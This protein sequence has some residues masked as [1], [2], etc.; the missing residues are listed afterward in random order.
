MRS[1]GA[2]SAALRP[3][4]EQRVSVLL[5]LPLAGAYD[6]AVPD[7]MKI[8]PGDFA[9]VPLGS[10][11]VVGVVWDKPLG[12][13]GGESVP[14]E[15]LREIEERLPAPPMPEAL[16][17]FIEWV[18]A[19]TVAPWGAVLRMALSAPAALLPPK[20]VLAARAADAPLEAFGLKQ[21][22]AR[23]RVVRLLADG[24]PRVLSE[25]AREAGVGAAVLRQMLQSGALEQVEM[26]PPPPFD[27]PDPARPGPALSDAQREAAG[28]LRERV[29][30]GYSVTLLDGV[31][32]SGKTEVYFE[33]I[34]AALDAGKQVLVLLPEIALSAQW[35][36]RFERRF[37]AK[38]AT[39]H[40]DLTGA[41]RRTT[42]RA[43]AEGTA[44][45]VVGARS[46][47]FLPLPELGLII[48]DE[49]HEG[50]YKQEDGV[51]YHA[52]DMAVVRAHLAGVPAMLVSATPSLETLVNVEAG[53]YGQVHLPDRHGGASMPQVQAIDLRR[54][55][56]PPRSWLAPRL[57]DALVET[58]A[59][60][61]QALL[62]L[63]RRGYAPLTLCKT[64][65]HRLSCPNCTAW[66]VEHRLAG[67]LQC[68]HCGYSVALPRQCP[69]C[70]TEASLVAYGPGVERVAEEVAAL[71]PEA[72][73]EVL[74]SDTMAGPATLAAL[75]ERM[76]K[77][78]I[79]ILIG[80][81]I[82]AKGHHFPDLTLVGVIDAD[83]GLAGGDLRAAE[84]TFQLLSQVA[85][86]AGRAERPGRVFLQT[87]DPA[88][89]VIAALV[90][91][92]RDRFIAEELEERKRAWMPPF[93]RL[94]A[95]VVQ[96]RDAET[97]D[98]LARALGRS[99]PKGD[100]IEVLGPAPAP[101]AVLRGWHRRRLL[102]RTRRDIAP[103]PL[104]RRWLEGVK[105]P[106]SARLAVDIDPYSFL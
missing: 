74:A 75:I 8:A 72:R 84:R 30:R 82:V 6:Y 22:P 57:K 97:A 48:V 28:A 99:R 69:A 86:R 76:E 21:T 58:F 47:L 13:A 94:A 61:E 27:A 10:R 98:G 71:F 26:P 95:I 41:Q 46:A 89:P 68:H 49:E 36:Q 32:G 50:A 62:Y 64:C 33:A 4:R 63:N 31:T 29:G 17:R 40:S 104:I 7:G 5:P 42:W 60:R 38:P 11:M 56:P 83:L 23:A 24:V 1:E 91:G 77:R 70:G 73:I 66:L 15:R 51:H 2:S 54:E 3:E 80:T 105:V 16:R 39:W 101:F 81:Q 87:Y 12:D 35:L 102:M 14:Q 34:A 78:E 85:G 9:L 67:R 45:L 19:Y 88:H 37:G 52:R 20:P 44:R 100:G 59:A 25:I 43:V 93:A 53:R 79:D 103:Q 65:G 96:A 55:K 90:A 92:D 106:S 18:A